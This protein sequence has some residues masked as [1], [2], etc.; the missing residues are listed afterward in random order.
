MCECVHLSMDPCES[1][2]QMQMDKEP[3]SSI[4]SPGEKKGAMTDR[5][6]QRRHTYQ[7]CLSE[8]KCILIEGQRGMTGECRAE[9]E[10]RGGGRGRHWLNGSGLSANPGAARQTA[11][12][13]AWRHGREEGWGRKRRERGQRERKEVQTEHRQL[14]ISHILAVIPLQLEVHPPPSGSFH[15]IPW[16]LSARQVSLTLWSSSLP[17]GSHLASE[18]AAY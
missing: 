10:E 16:F 11:H 2:S 6:P 3:F 15:H 14:V 4:C 18:R 17:P 8:K 12:V 13:A 5:R 1:P 7:T 9:D